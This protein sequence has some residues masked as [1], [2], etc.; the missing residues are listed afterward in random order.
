MEKIY[1][2]KSNKKQT[3]VAI[4]ASDKRDI[5]TEMLLGIYKD[6]L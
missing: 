4:Q 1:H 3:R 2:V 5:K 6:I